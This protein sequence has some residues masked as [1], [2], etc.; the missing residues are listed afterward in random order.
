LQVGR[1]ERAQSWLGELLMQRDRR[2]L[3]PTAPAHG[4]Y[5]TDVRYGD[6]WHFPPGRPPAILRALGDVW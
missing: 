3:G 1:G 5:L 4:L 2:Q 6:R